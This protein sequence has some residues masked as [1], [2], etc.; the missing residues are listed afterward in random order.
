MSPMEAYG[1]ISRMYSELHTM[2]V[3]LYP[4]IR[5]YSQEEVTAQVIV[6]EAL[7]RMEEEDDKNTE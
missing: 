6:F 2:R 7:R 5:P 3:A 4:A 1:I